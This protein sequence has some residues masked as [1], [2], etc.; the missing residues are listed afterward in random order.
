MIIYEVTNKYKTMDELLF[1]KY[2]PTKDQALDN[3]A[4]NDT[5]YVSRD[6]CDIDAVIN[7]NGQTLIGESPYECTINGGY[8]SN[9]ISYYASVIGD[10]NDNSFDGE[11]INYHFDWI[12]GNP[13]HFFRDV[14]LT[15]RNCIFT[16]TEE[17]SNLV[18]FSYGSSFNIYNIAYIGKNLGPS[19]SDGIHNNSYVL[20]VKCAVICGYYR[21]IRHRGISSST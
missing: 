9:E 1:S 7:M 3:T 21:S 14:N 5:I 11:I 12:F 17:G 20:S 16:Q 4:R 15:I 18:N 19:R 6:R 2:Y 8:F 10:D 13:G